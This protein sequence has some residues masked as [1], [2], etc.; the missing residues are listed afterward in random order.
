MKECVIKKVKIPNG[1]TI[2]YREA[3]KG[4]QTIILIHGNMSSS[5]FFDNLIDELY[6]NYKIYA[7]DLR[8][9][10]DSSYE[11]PFDSLY[12]LSEDIKMWID[13]LGLD[14]M[15]VLGWSTGGG[16]AME[17]AASYPN[18]IKGLICLD[19]VGTMGYPILK[20]DSLV[21]VLLSTREEIA[22]DPIQVAPVA[23]AY[24]TGDRMFMR[25]LYDTTVF[26]YKKPT[27]EQWE[28]YLDAMFKQRNLID[29]D[30]SLANFNISGKSNGLSKGN[31]RAANI[32]CPTLV[33]NGREDIISPIGMAQTIVD[34]IPQAE[35][36]IVDKCGHSMVTDNLPELVRQINKFCS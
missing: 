15:Y 5:V 24:A 3:G 19:S 26:L 13:E 36:V 20:K 7:P 28:R 10:G 11:K 2:A 4:T 21:P 6:D 1:E 16:V 17:L 25:N 9:M 23:R 33:L 14:Q 32:K 8:G 27:E 18:M 22:E 12:E 30:Y 34:S 35:F 31:N 29:I